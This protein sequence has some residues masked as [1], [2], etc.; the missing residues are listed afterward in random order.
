MALPAFHTAIGM[1]V[2]FLIGLIGFLKKRKITR[3]FLIHVSIWMII[4]GLWAEIPD[5]PRFFPR[6]HRSLEKKITISFY[7]NV[8][9]FHGFLD[10]H[11][12]EDRGLLEGSLIIFSMFFFLLFIGRKS[13]L[14]NEKEI[15][16]LGK[17][18]TTCQF[19]L[20]KK[21]YVFENI[22]D[23][24]CHILP[25]VDDGPQT[26][27]ESLKMCKR[28][29][30]LGIS[31]IIA[32]PHFPWEGR[33]DTTRILKAYN[34]LSERLVKE[35][36][37]I[38]LSLGSDCRITHDLVERLKKKEVFRLANS[39]FFLLELDDFTVPEGLELFI[40]HSR[41]EGFFPILTHPERN[42]VFQSNF[43]RLEKIKEKGKANIFFAPNLRKRDLNSNNRK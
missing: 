4:C 36:C 23:I 9:F 42:I 28:A 43:K 1:S 30:E 26:I 41:E 39:R 17:K 6:K 31:H 20:Q 35:N 34:S 14:D 25:G 3:R 11:Q 8:F 22:I 2:P 40:A 10:A 32:T 37:D 16:L 15:E 19:N 12:T 21:D 13:L 18:V 29:K 7:G 38:T 24:H 27:E 5:F 33:Y